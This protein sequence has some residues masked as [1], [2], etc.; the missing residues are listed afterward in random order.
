[1]IHTFPGQDLCPLSDRSYIPPPPCAWEADLVVVY[2]GTWLVYPISY[3]FIFVPP[4]WVIYS[5]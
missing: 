1:M 2:A 5:I 3:Y 4:T